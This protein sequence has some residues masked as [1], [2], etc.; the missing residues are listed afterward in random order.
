MA[1]L[2]IAYWFTPSESISYR[3]SLLANNRSKFIELGGFRAHYLE[4]GAGPPLLM[5]HGG[6]TWLFSFQ[7]NLEPLARSFRVIALDMPGHG[8]TEPTRSATRYDFDTT[9][10]VLLEFLDAKGI[11]RVSLVGRSWGGGWALHFAQCHPERV[12][13]LVLIASSGL[14]GDDR[15]DRRVR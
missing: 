9:D 1:V 6:G 7:H 12:R 5:V 15:F 13:K 8:Y 4:Q 2:Y 11:S 14:P 3:S 10:R